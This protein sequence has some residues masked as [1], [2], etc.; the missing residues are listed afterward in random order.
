MKRSVGWHR[1]RSMVVLL[2]LLALG[3]MPAQAKIIKTYRLQIGNVNDAQNAEA[4]RQRAVKRVPIPVFVEELH[5][6]YKVTAGEFST[7]REAAA[8]KDRLYGEGFEGA[9]VVEVLTSVSDQPT[10]PAIYKVQ[11]GNFAS[12]VN[13]RQLQ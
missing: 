6:Q 13:A 1:A 9:F 3:G 8:Y 10:G 2:L 11:V 12:L 7:Y 5:G 4:L